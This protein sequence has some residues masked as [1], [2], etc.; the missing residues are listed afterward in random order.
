MTSPTASSRPRRRWRTFWPKIGFPLRRDY[1][2][3]LDLKTNE[4][5]KRKSRSTGKVADDCK[6][7]ALYWSQGR[8]V[9]GVYLVA[10]SGCAGWVAWDDF[11]D[12]N[13]PQLVEFNKRQTPAAFTVPI[14]FPPYFPEEQ[15][16]QVQQ[17]WNLW[18]SAT[19]FS[20]RKPE[21]HSAPN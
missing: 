12:L 11:L 3:G 21:P 19:R 17:M 13:L 16:L 4:G 1:F 8:N 7:D 2:P 14:Q 9:P 15:K 10:S 18:Q 6:C 5:W 20:P